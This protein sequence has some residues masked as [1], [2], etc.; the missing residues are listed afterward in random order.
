[1]SHNIQ[2]FAYIQTTSY[3]NYL[4]C[5]YNTIQFI[6][7][8]PVQTQFSSNDRNCHLKRY[9]NTT[10]LQYVLM[11][12]IW[13]KLYFLHFCNLYEVKL[14]IKSKFHLINCMELS[15]KCAL[16][17]DFR[18]NWTQNGLY[19]TII[20]YA[21]RGNRVYIRQKGE[22]QGN[23]RCYFVQNDENNCVTIW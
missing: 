23:N 12:C 1:M 8:S 19:Q 17:T 20:Q 21:Q 7:L 11:W 16:C 13:G 15:K 18:C 6:K 3:S 4:N 9:H 14:P 2:Y 22:I 10:L 5:T